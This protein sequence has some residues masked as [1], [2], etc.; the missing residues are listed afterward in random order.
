MKNDE[1]G[2]MVSITA[3]ITVVQVLVFFQEKTQTLQIM[4]T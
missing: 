3:G 1:N 2:T 4:N